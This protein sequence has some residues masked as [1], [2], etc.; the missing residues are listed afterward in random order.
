[1]QLS[2]QYDYDISKLNGKFSSKN[3]MQENVEKG[4]FKHINRSKF[5]NF[6]NTI[7][8]SKL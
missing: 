5:L 2:I 1:M 8:C 6:F 3:C 4:K 7:I